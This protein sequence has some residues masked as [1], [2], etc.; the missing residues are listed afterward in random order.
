MNMY[1]LV[2]RALPDKMALVRQ[3]LLTV[4][5]LELH[6][7]HEGRLIVT[8]EDVPGY[9]TSEALTAIQSFDGIISTTLAYEYCDDEQ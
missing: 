3:Q 4:P 8:V 5:G 9:R 1:S 2:V 7:E 6:Q